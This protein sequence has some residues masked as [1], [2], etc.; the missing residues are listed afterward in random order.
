MISNEVEKMCAYFRF[1]VTTYKVTIINYSS[2]HGQGIIERHKRFSLREKKK[3][4]KIQDE[5]N[6]TSERNTVNQLIDTAH[7]SEGQKVTIR[8]CN[9]IT[10]EK[11]S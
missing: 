1:R 8:H 4:K 7:V 3:K 5:T 11:N 9:S 6:V 2:T 10:R